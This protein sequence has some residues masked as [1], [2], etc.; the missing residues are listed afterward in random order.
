HCPIFDV[1]ELGWSEEAVGVVVARLQQSRGPEQ[2]ADDVGVGRDHGTPLNMVAVA[3]A[4]RRTRGMAWSSLSAARPRSGP[5]ADRPEAP[6][7]RMPA[8]GPRAS[9]AE[10]VQ[11]LAQPFEA[12]ADE[13]APCL[14][15]HPGGVR[16]Q[17]HVGEAGQW[18]TRWQR[19][20]RED[21]EAG[22]GDL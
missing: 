8:I 16:G 20:L 21:V 12:K 18:M 4:R 17:G 9:L 5:L 15:T 13:A 1:L 11:L 10:T 3:A 14:G 19:L 22:G 7:R 2:A 6:G